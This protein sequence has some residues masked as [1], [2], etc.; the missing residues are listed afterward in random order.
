MIYN[1]EVTNQDLARMDRAHVWHPYTSFNNP[2]MVTP[3]SHAQGVE[4][5][6][7]DGRVLIDG[8]SSWWSAV[9]G[10][11]HPVLNQAIT[12]QLGKMAHVMFAG[13]THD[14]AVKLASTLAKITPSGLNKV[15]FSDSGSVAVE[16]ALKMAIQY[17]RTEKRLSRRYFRCYVGVRSP[18]RYAQSVLSLFTASFFC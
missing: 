3:V 14:P 7:A 13:I 6:L 8:M 4:L 16:I 12:D 18:F 1:E 10:Y 2:G 9:H 17:S 11:N 15:F 5:H